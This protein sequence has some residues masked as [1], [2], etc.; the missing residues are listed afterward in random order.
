[1]IRIN[2]TFA[3]ASAILSPG[4]ITE[5]LG[6]EPDS[7]VIKG[8]ERATPKANP[9]RHGWYISVEGENIN[10]PII[11]LDKLLDRV[12]GL[13]ERIPSI[14][15]ADEKVNVTIHISVVSSNIVVPLFFNRDTLMRVTALGASL[16][17]DFFLIDA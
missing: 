2:V 15:A 9:P 7:S 10:N 16:D 17:V 1:M 5:I 3:I 6:V 14:A 12:S 11:L 8:S 4:E 13:V